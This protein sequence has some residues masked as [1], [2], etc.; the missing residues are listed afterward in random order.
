MANATQFTVSDGMNGKNDDR[1]HVGNS[2]KSSRDS[3]RHSRP[4]EF[5]KSTFFDFSSPIYKK[6]GDILLFAGH[7]AGHVF[8]P[9]AVFAQHG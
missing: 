3:S 5:L 9:L 6:N 2:G 1:S 4:R 8:D 7:R